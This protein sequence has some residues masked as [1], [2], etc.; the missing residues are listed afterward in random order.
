MRKSRIVTAAVA[1]TAASV[2]AAAPAVAQRGGFG[3]QP[4]VPA[5]PNPPALSF[6]TSNP[7]IRQIW[8]I[9]VD[10]SHVKSLSQT[11]FDSLGP[12]L[13]GAPKLSTDARFATLA[14]RRV[15][16]DASS[17]SCRRGR[18]IRTR[19]PSPRSC[20]TAVFPRKQSRT[21]TTCSRRRR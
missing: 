5:Y 4:A 8:A 6:P 11:L 17:R 16:E 20:G 2:L 1:A 13:M 12:R 21:S 15:H 14:A 7:I 3:G 9:G 10:S 19:S 18:R